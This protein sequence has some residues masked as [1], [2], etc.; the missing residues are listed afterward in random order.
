MDEFHFINTY[1][2]CTKDCDSSSILY[3]HSKISSSNVVLPSKLFH[4]WFQSW[5]SLINLI[6][7]PWERSH[8]DQSKWLIEWKTAT[9]AN[10]RAIRSRLRGGLFRSWRRIL[11]GNGSASRIRRW[12]QPIP[13]A[14]YSCSSCS[15]LL[16]GD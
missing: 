15:S 12:Q 4:F 8:F 13:G 5:E 16:K 2:K 3:Y 9:I 1:S 14:E 7:V 11:T 10:A 6:I